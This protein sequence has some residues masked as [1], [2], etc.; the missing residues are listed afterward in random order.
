MFDTYFNNIKSYLIEVKFENQD[1]VRGGQEKDIAISEESISGVT[2]PI[3]YKAWLRVFGLGMSKKLLDGNHIT[4]STL[5]EASKEA[6]KNR[7]DII[8]YQDTLFI[9]YEDTSESY[10]V[11]SSGSFLDDPKVFVFIADD[12]LLQIGNCFT[13]WVRESIIKMMKMLNHLERMSFNKE[14]LALDSFHAGVN[15]AKTIK[16]NKQREVFIANI[17]NRDNQRGIIT[18]P[19][20]FQK[21]WVSYMEDNGMDE[22]INW[23][24]EQV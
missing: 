9:N 3:A 16:Y 4:I 5:L 17:E 10:T 11:L 23:K 7:Y 6:Y 20:D 24:R 18:M 21:E 14:W 15:D 1:S 8:N 2:F 19:D 12:E 13:S 22:Y